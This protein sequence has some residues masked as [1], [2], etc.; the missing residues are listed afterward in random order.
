MAN[1][2]D[3]LTKKAWFKALPTDERDAAI[4]SLMQ[5]PHVE[6]QIETILDNIDELGWADLTPRQEQEQI[7]GLIKLE[8]SIRLHRQSL[9][10]LPWYENLGPDE[11]E[12]VRLTTEL[13]SRIQLAKLRPLRPPDEPQILATSPWQQVL[14]QGRIGAQ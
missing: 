1:V 7:M 2:I 11:Q 9:E 3:R 5:D 14:H 8:Q 6:G 13:N 10:E 12:A 4:A